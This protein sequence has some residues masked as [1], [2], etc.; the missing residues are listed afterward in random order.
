MQE[1]AQSQRSCIRCTK[2]GFHD[3]SGEIITCLSYSFQRALNIELG[4]FRKLGLS[5]GR[6]INVSQGL[7]AAEGKLIGADSHSST[8][9]I[10]Q[11][12]KCFMAAAP[13]YADLI[14]Y[15]RDSP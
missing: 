11:C 9:L 13:Q 7:E 10:M 2:E 3:E 15:V 5:L 4:V 6:L 1:S 14:G 8:V 12:E